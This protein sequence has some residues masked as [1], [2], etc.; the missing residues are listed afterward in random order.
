[1]EKYTQKGNGEMEDSLKVDCGKR[2]FLSRPV[3][4]HN[5]FL[6][7]KNVSEQGPNADQFKLPIT[8]PPPPHPH[9]PTKNPLTTNKSLSPIFYFF[10]LSFHKSPRPHKIDELLSSTSQ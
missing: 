7:E 3:F 8:P 6:S 10:S 4:G 2:V 1:M 5:P 9:T